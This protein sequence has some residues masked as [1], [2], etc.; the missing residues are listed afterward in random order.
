MAITHDALNRVGISLPPERFEDLVIEAVEQMRD[1][2]AADPARDLTRA[3]TEVLARGGFEL[4]ARDLGDHDPLA[5]TV[6]E[7]AALLATSLTVEQAAKLL[8][9]DPSRVRQ[10]LAARTLYGIK[11]HRGWRLPTFQFEDSVGTLPGLEEV[12]PA[13]DPD[14]HPISVYRWLVTPSPDLEI[15]GEAVSPTVWLRAGGTPRQAAEIAA[16]LQPARDSCRSSRN[17]HL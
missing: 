8:G 10:R 14:L 4:D 6:A 11:T 7:Y 3:E 2:V 16:S 15:D 13:L 17:R 1:V 12:L 9:V 5:R